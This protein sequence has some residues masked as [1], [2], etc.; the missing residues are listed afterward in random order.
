LQ[1]NSCP[2]RS[3]A[4]RDRDGSVGVLLLA[5]RSR[6]LGVLLLA[7]RS[8]IL[9]VLLLACRSRILSGVFYDDRLQVLG[10]SAPRRPVSPNV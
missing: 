10:T 3:I 6:I 8:R 1:L 2:S 4:D 7:C 9:S 5:C